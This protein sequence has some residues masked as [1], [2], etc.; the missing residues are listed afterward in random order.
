MREY[1]SDERGR[2]SDESRLESD[3]CD[4]ESDEPTPE[5]DDRLLEAEKTN[6]QFCR[7]IEGQNWIMEHFPIPKSESVIFPKS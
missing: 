2:E 5:S 6:F 7:H 3:D 1:E 4:S